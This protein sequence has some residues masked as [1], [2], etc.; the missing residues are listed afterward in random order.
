MAMLKKREDLTDRKDDNTLFALGLTDNF[1]DFFSVPSME[2][3]ENI[4]PELEN[5]D[6]LDLDDETRFKVLNE[7]NNYKKSK[8]IKEQE[9]YKRKINELLRK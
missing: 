4:I 9:K 3:K 1:G 6:E 7:Y 5:I 8:S 2:V